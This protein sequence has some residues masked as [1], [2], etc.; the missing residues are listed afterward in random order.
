MIVV[1]GQRLSRQ[2]ALNRAQGFVRTLGVVQG[3]RSLARW[4]APICPKVIGLSPEHSRIV[5]DRLHATIMAVGAPLAKGACD[6]NLLVAF[7][8]DGKQMVNIIDQKQSRRMAQ[9][10]GP[11]RRA[12]LES[13]APIRWW[14]MIDLG[15]GDGAGVGSNAPPGVGGNS[16]TGSPMWDGI[17]TSQ[18]YG[19]SLIRSPVIRMISAATV[20]IDVN[21]AEGVSLTSVIDYAAFVGLAEVRARALP[22]LPSILNLFGSRAE[23]AEGSNHA[24]TDWDRR[25]LVRLYTLPL[26]RLASAQRNRLV[27]ALLDEDGPDTAD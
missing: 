25:F 12:L 5:M 18:S 4:V 7:V 10:Q 6:T 16:D 26:N 21:R 14:Y 17:P 8:S 15:S 9:V 27:N 11:D 1:Q 23:G 24:L 19:S 2:E 20:L 13:D 3:D 22:P